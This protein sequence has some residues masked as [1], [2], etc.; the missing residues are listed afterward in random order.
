MST[1]DRILRHATDIFFTEGVATLTMDRLADDLGMSKR[2]LYKRVGTKE[3][4]LRAIVEG[5]LSLIHI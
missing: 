2:T 4:L 1:A 5:F 3:E